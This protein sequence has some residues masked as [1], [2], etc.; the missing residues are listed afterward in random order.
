MRQDT[1]TFPMTRQGVRNLD[2]AP[3]DLLPISGG[4]APAPARPS[5]AAQRWG[6]VAGGGALLLFGLLRGTWTGL[7][8][9][10]TGGALLCCGLP[11][12]RQ[13]TAAGSRGRAGAFSGQEVVYRAGPARG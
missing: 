13:N 4:P 9:A 11:A 3:R 6:L 8:V 10:L 12:G 1:M 7:G 5:G 2:S